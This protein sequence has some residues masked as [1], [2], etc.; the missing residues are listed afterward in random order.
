MLAPCVLRTG[1]CCSIVL[2]A[3]AAL[4]RG[5]VVS[6]VCA[7]VLVLLLCLAV[8]DLLQRKHSILRNYPMAGH[9]RFLFEAIRPELQQSFI[10]PGGRTDPADA[11]ALV[12]P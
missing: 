1:R 9:L 7:V 3:V 5:G 10:E 4:A 12:G 11:A 2:A 6:I 8:H